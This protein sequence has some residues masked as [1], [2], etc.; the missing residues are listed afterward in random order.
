[1]SDELIQAIRDHYELDLYGQSNFHT[2]QV[3]FRQDCTIGI[4]DFDEYVTVTG[5]PEEV[6]WRFTVPEDIEDEVSVRS[7]TT[8]RTVVAEKKHKIRHNF[9]S[10][11][12]CP[13]ET[14]VQLREVFGTLGDGDDILTPDIISTDVNGVIHVVEVSTTR[15][16]HIPSIESAYDLKHYKYLNALVN[17]QVDNIIT[18]T[19]IIVS[20]HSVWS[21][22][23]LPMSMVNDLVVR[24]RIACALENAGTACRFNMLQAEDMG[25]SEIIAGIISE[26]ISS[27][28]WKYPPEDGYKVYITQQFVKDALGPCNMSVAKELFVSCRTRAAMQE[29]VPDSKRMVSQ[30]IREMEQ[31]QDCRGDAKPV[32]VFPL[33]FVKRLDD[34]TLVRRSIGSGDLPDY[35]KK[36]WN[37]AESELGQKKYEWERRQEKDLVKEAF[38]RGREAIAE[39]EKLRLSRRSKNY[40]VDM[41]PVLKGETM[42]MLQRDG[43]FRKRIANTLE[44]KTRRYQQSLS[45]SWDT[46]ISDIDEWINLDLLKQLV[47]TEGKLVMPRG[48]EWPMELVERAH[49]LSDNHVFD[50]NTLKEWMSTKAFHTFDFISNLATELASAIK[51]NTNQDHMIMRK[52][53]GYDAYMLCKTTNSDSHLFFSL[54][55]PLEESVELIDIRCFR[56]LYKAGKGYATD[57]TSIRKDKLGNM[58]NA[59]SRFL[60]MVSFWCDFYGINSLTVSD[61]KENKEAMKMLQLS[62]LISLEDKAET[63]ETITLTRYMYMELFKSTQS[64]VLPNPM[65][66]LSKFS[67]KPR[68]RLNLWCMKRVIQAFSTMV[69]FPP[70]RVIEKDDPGGEDALPGDRWKNLVNPFTGGPVTTATALVNLMYLGYLKDKNEQGQGNSEMKLVE[71]IVEEEGKLT[72]SRRSEQ[73]GEASKK[74]PPRGKGFSLDCLKHGCDIM[75]KKLKLSKGENYKDKLLQEIILNLGRHLTHTLATLKASAK[76]DPTKVNESSSIKDKMHI[77]RVKVIEALAANLKLFGLNPFRN[78]KAILEFMESTAKGVMC[79]LFKKQQHGGL[80]EIYVLNI[81]SR[82]LQLFVETIARTLCGHFEEETLTHPENKIKKLDEHKVRSALIA[83]KDNSIYADF[84]SSSDKTRWNQNFIMTAMSVPLL[85]LTHESLHPTIVRVLNLW[86][87]KLI[88]IPPAV[89]KMMMEGVELSSDAYK[90]VRDKFHGIPNPVEGPI[91]RSRF[92]PYLNLT[93]GMMQGILHYTSSLLHVACLASSKEMAMSYLRKTHSDRSVRFTMTSVCSSDDSATIL[94]AFSKKEHLDF[95]M[96]D[97]K[98]FFHCDIMLHALTKYSQF[99]CMEE[100]VKSTISCYDYVEF[101]SEFLFKNTIAMPTIKFVAACTTIT[102]SESLA[103]RQ[104]EMYNLISALSGSSF[105]MINTYFC[106]ISQALLH[107]KSMGANASSLFPLYAQRLLDYPDFVHG[108]FLLDSELL[109]GVMGL[110]FARWKA[111]RKEKVLLAAGSLHKSSESEVAEDGTIMDSLTV[112]HGEHYRWYKLLDRVSDGNLNVAPRSIKKDPITGM[113]VENKSVLRE[114]L[115]KINRNPHLLYRHPEDVGELRI[116]LVAKALN[117][118]VSKSLSKGNPIVQAFSSTTY[119]LYAHCYTRVTTTKR[120][121]DDG[122]LS[123][124][125]MVNKISILQSLDE[126]MEYVESLKDSS[127]LST[128][129]QLFPLESEYLVAEQVLSKYENYQWLIAPRLR[130]RK[131]VVSV[132]PKTGKIPL[133]LLQVCERRWFGTHIKASQRVIDR[134]WGEYLLA[135]PWL[136]DTIEDSLTASPFTLHTEMHGFISGVRAQRRTYHRVGPSTG[137]TRLAHQLFQMI[138]RGAMRNL[139]LD[140]VTGLTPSIGGFPKVGGDKALEREALET[141]LSLALFIPFDS[142]RKHQVGKVLES[143]ARMKP[144]VEDWIDCPNW[145]FEV[146]MIA[147]KATKRITDVELNEAMREKGSGI[148]IVFTQ[149]QRKEREHGE[150]KW[151]GPGSC[152]IDAEGVPLRATLMDRTVTSITCR[153]FARLKNRPDLLRAV[154]KRLQSSPKTIAN[155]TN[156]VAVFNGTRFMHPGSPGTPIIVD[157]WLEV[158]HDYTSNLKVLIQPGSVSVTTS[159]RRPIPMVSFHSKAWVCS[160]ST[161]S[162]T[163]VDDMWNAWVQG[164]PATT[165][166]IISVLHQAHSAGDRLPQRIRSWLKESLLNRLKVKGIGNSNL[167]EHAVDLA[168]TVITSEEEDEMKW[169]EEMYDDEYGEGNENSAMDLFQSTVMRGL[170]PDLDPD[171]DEDLRRIYEESDFSALLGASVNDASPFRS[172]IH[173]FYE[174]ETEFSFRVTNPRELSYYSLHPMWDCF[175]KDIRHTSPTFFSLVLDGVLP[176]SNR[177]TAQI[178]MDVMQISIRDKE[179]DAL[180]QF[181]NSPRDPYPALD[182]DSETEGMEE[183]GEDM[184]SE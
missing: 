112:R 133:S 175:I 101:N 130:Q 8:S 86:S 2:S 51:Q 65:K 172:V 96:D 61:F 87:N 5:T 58:L 54:M 97:V 155:L 104:Y 13:V 49:N 167:L 32:T 56:K 148:K 176:V 95:T 183:G 139:L 163:P 165:A 47:D 158:S 147:L 154:F 161:G 69:D 117:P 44:A 31:R 145:E 92:S 14:D 7:S 42:R 41:K 77:T 174:E 12:L 6:S 15:S 182:M 50:L 25:M 66:I 37:H 166:S 102:E 121:L 103:R 180:E 111:V 91:V 157:P 138:R 76:L 125:K 68:S 98:T 48:Q 35:M 173:N 80:R 16:T 57:F 72:T 4:I 60:A 142:E 17:R 63:E 19:V 22:V 144:K 136:R 79:D 151:V 11:G 131:T 88:K 156:A 52:I 90:L 115:N 109:C 26:N 116:K 71:K 93:T 36:I 107:Y 143:L 55:F 169:L 179:L 159:G 100:S 64:R 21:S 146:G 171:M 62:M 85:R 160:I 1:M 118:G 10:E 162:S 27:I 140:T 29:V 120:L 43:L 105:P 124:E 39:Y 40:R 127:E 70:I 110:S 53:R 82:I 178:I 59:S 74:D 170:D 67:R 46:P 75:D 34:D 181:L 9:V 150:Q 132:I 113:K 33:A 99:F 94:T 78:F 106:Q 149:E 114:H 177:A 18:Y 89:L 123:S 128:S 84:C 38:C 81:E 129:D 152:I 184:D 153:N 30:F 83:R 134:C 168:T 3:P 135:Y 164:R 24:M 141:N 126:R 73:Y 28:E 119:A 137:T 20:Q 45:F 122:T 23:R 108:F